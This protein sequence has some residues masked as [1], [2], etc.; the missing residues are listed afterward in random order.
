MAILAKKEH[1]KE[2]IEIKEKN[3]GEREEKKLKEKIE[4]KEMQ[5]RKSEGAIKMHHGFMPDSHKSVQG[6]I[7]NNFCQNYTSTHISSRTIAQPGTG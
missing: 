2:L 1:K 7:T 4:N 5:K 6:K 3:K